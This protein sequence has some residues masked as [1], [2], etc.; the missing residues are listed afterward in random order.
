VVLAAKPATVKR[1]GV[2]G[3]RLRAQLLRKF[4]GGTKLVG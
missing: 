1:R 3:L 4:Q 2:S